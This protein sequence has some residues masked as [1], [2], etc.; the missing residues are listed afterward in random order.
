M[1]RNDIER[2]DKVAGVVEP[3]YLITDVDIKHAGLH[4]VEADSHVQHV[5]PRLPALESLA[6][7]VRD[8]SG[9]M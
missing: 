2:E 3:M 9:R 4:V 1:T 7:V 8:L 6:Y 5:D